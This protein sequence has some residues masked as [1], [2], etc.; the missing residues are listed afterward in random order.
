MPNKLLRVTPEEELAIREA[1]LQG[2][3]LKVRLG[4]EGADPSAP[5]RKR[6]ADVIAA[7]NL[8]KRK[9]SSRG[10]DLTDAGEDINISHGHREV[11]EALRIDGERIGIVSD[12]HVPSHDK[13]AT[14]A[15][16]RFLKAKGIDTLIINGDFMDMYAISDHDKSKLRQITFGD[17]LEEGRTILKQIREYFGAS[18]RII[19]QEGNHEERYAR[20]LPQAMAGDKVRGSTIREQLELDSVNIEWVGDRRGID[21]GSLRV[22]HGHELRA[23]GVNPTRAMLTKTMHNT[24]VGHLHR[25][26]SLVR[27]KLTGEPIGAWVTGCLCDLRPHYAPVNEWVHGFAYFE[28]DTTGEF[29]PNNYTIRNGKVYAS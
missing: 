14:E 4:A 23:A 8:A 20:F 9:P 15:A 7:E 12:I 11:L 6:T 19:Y 25:S 22:Y 27:P 13:V 29:V 26:H 17:E 3:A 5:S 21:I 2:L 18:V 24:I 16:L 28:F 10:L 1:R